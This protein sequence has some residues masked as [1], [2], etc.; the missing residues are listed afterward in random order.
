MLHRGPQQ[1]KTYTVALSCISVHRCFMFHRRMSLTTAL[2]QCR[3]IDSC[4]SLIRPRCWI[5]TSLRLAETLSTE[6][7]MSRE[8]MRYDGDSGQRIRQRPTLYFSGGSKCVP[9]G[10]APL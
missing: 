3:R 7:A 8:T 9:H 10:Y 6:L 2:F 5:Q 4:V 1:W